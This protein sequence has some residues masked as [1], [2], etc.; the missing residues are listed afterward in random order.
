MSKGTLV[1]LGAGVVVLVGAGIYLTIRNRQPSNPTDSRAGGVVPIYVG[2]AFNPLNPAGPPLPNAGKVGTTF[3]AVTGA[4]QK[5]V[6]TTKQAIA[7][8]EEGKKVWSDLKELF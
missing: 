3:Q 8:F 1:A 5:G 7:T 2:G 4:V 6:D